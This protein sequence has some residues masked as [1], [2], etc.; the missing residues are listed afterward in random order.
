MTTKQI[1]TVFD[2]QAFDAADPECETCE[3]TGWIS[4]VLDG[5]NIPCICLSITRKELFAESLID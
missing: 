4:D 2:K 5:E 3:G 1:E